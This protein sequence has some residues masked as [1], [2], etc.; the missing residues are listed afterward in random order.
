MSTLNA[1][2]E[3]PAASSW[4]PKSIILPILVTLCCCLPG[5][6]I[7]LVFTL[8]ANS[9][10]A[11]GNLQLAEKNAKNAQLCMIVSAVIGVIAAVLY[12]VFMMLGV[13]AEIASE[14]AR[15]E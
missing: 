3:A 9:A 1:G 10:G 5:G 2:Q 13:A 6:V 8:Q 4:I 7:A 11:M 15:T 14:S 12:V